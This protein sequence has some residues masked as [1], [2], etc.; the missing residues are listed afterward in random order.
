MCP[1]LVLIRM[2]G[3]E[4]PRSLTASMLMALLAAD[5]HRCINVTFRQIGLSDKLD[6]FSRLEEADGTLI[7]DEISREVLDRIVE[8]NF[9]CRSG[10]DP[11]KFVYRITPDGR[12]WAKTNREF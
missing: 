9:V 6:A 3:R 7:T 12:T 5:P 10:S 11:L 8:E 1:S 2:K 4:R